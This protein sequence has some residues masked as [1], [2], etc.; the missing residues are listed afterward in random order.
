MRLSL[1]ELQTVKKSRSMEMVQRDAR[2][3][4]EERRKAA[5]LLESRMMKRILWAW[6]PAQSASYVSPHSA[7]QAAGT[8][9]PARHTGTEGQAGREEA[10]KAGRHGG[11]G[12]YGRE[13]HQRWVG[14]VTV[15]M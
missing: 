6:W 14:A 4:D 11:E 12:G 10:R 9:R 8:P 15:C 1:P 7:R 3:H 5:A 2:G 13:Q